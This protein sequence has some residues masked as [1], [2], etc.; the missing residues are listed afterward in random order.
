MAKEKK[1]KINYKNLKVNQE[2]LSITKIGQLST[3]D[4][5]PIFIIVL[6]GFILIFIFFLPTIT[7]YIKGNNK[8]TIYETPHTD[9]KPEEPLIPEEETKMYTIED[10]L[11]ISLE[12][13]INLSQFVLN[14]DILSF[15]VTN[16]GT[17]R[18]D[19]DAENYFLELY[20][21]D[22]TL[23]E[24]I[25]LEGV[26][27]RGASLTINVSL[28]NNSVENVE[29]ISFVTKEVTDY[30]NVNLRVNELEEEVLT[31][32]NS[33]ET[34]TYKFQNE[35]LFEITDNVNVNSNNKEYLNLFNEWKVKTETLN[36][37]DGVTSVFVDTGSN[38]VANTTIDLKT[39]KLKNEGKYYY[40]NETLA[41]VVHFE[42]ESRGFSCK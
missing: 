35:K 40:E 11:S 32:S 1:D 19:F 14:E 10:A 9:P 17:N 5:S 21:S 16:M 24:R 39:A 29:K 41:K 22:S 38:F 27:N 23:L 37:I 31:C 18:F 13:N 20:S 4:Q 42:M 30:P 34:L 26:V 15:Q 3:A 6:F 8:E 7:N 33:I 25:L 36:N 12:E 2:E 28:N